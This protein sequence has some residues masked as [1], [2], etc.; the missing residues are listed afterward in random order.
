MTQTG[1]KRMFNW[2]Q[3]AVGVFGALCASG[4]RREL[5]MRILIDTKVY[6]DG[7]KSSSLNVVAAGGQFSQTVCISLNRSWH[8]CR[9]LMLLLSL[10]PNWTLNLQFLEQ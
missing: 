1:H 2:R 8:C 4:G 6:L 10:L 7:T 9:L 3:S 5:P